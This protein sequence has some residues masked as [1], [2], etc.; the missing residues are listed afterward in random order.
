[1]VCSYL[2]VI[3]PPDF[4]K[5]PVWKITHR[6][7]SCFNQANFLIISEG[8]WKWPRGRRDHEEEA[9]NQEEKQHFLRVNECVN[10][11]APSDSATS[12]P[13]HIHTH[14]HHHQRS[15]IPLN[16]CSKRCIFSRSLRSNGTFLNWSC[17]LLPWADASG[18]SL[19]ESELWTNTGMSSVG[20]WCL[21]S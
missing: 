9:E 4:N 13:V 11:V 12:I 7:S 21:Q 17:E 1:M 19:T 14:T 10:K 20:S 8:L 6:F 2:T 5:S 3:P 18:L 16:T 15:Y